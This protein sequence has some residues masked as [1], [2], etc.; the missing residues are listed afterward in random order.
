MDVPSGVKDH[1]ADQTDK[2]VLEY[3]KQG[4]YERSAGKWA[5]EQEP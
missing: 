3:V 5:A 1:P 2:A 4:V